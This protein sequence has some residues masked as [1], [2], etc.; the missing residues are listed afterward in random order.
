MIQAARTQVAK[1]VMLGLT[2][3]NAQRHEPLE[4]PAQLWWK[5][6]TAKWETLWG[7]LNEASTDLSN[8]AKLKELQEVSKAAFRLYEQLTVDAM[9]ALVEVPS[10]VLREEAGRWRET[11]TLVASLHRHCIMG[12]LEE[13]SKNPV[14]SGITEVKEAT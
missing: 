1:G 8:F 4:Q 12:K 13:A 7:M 6:Q 10:E 9:V 2:H 14:F 5:A 11:A 3:A